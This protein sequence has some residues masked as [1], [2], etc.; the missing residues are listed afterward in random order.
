[1]KPFRISKG[2]PPR[3]R[4]SLKPLPTYESSSDQGYPAHYKNRYEGES[5]DQNDENSRIYSQKPRL[6]PKSHNFDMTSNLSLP[7]VRKARI[8]EFEH[9]IE[10]I[11]SSN[12]QNK[13]KKISNIILILN[14]CLLLS[15]DSYISFISEGDF[16]EGTTNLSYDSQL[17][18]Q[19]ADHRISNFQHLANSWRETLPEIVL[20][21]SSL[22][23]LLKLVKTYCSNNYLRF[24][25]S[26]NVVVAFNLI[27]EEDRGLRL[28]TS[29]DQIS[30]KSSDTK[31]QTL[32]NPMGD[33]HSRK[34]GMSG[35]SSQSQQY[36]NILKGVK[37]FNNGVLTLRKMKTDAILN[38]RYAKPDTDDFEMREVWHTYFYKAI[39]SLSD[40][41]VLRKS[42][43]TEAHKRYHSGDSRV[44]RK[45]KSTGYS[46]QDAAYLQSVDYIVGYAYY[47]LGVLSKSFDLR[48]AKD[49]LERSYQFFYNFEDTGMLENINKELYGLEYQRGYD[50]V[51]ILDYAH[52][53]FNKLF[54]IADSFVPLITKLPKIDLPQFTYYKG[55]ASQN[56]M[57]SVT[58]SVS[59]KLRLY[60][61]TESSPMTP[62][63]YILKSP[64]EEIRS[65]SNHRENPNFDQMSYKYYRNSKHKNSHKGRNRPM[66]SQHKTQEIL[67]RKDYSKE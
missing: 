7:I 15:I 44:S 26:S 18:Q 23:K 49:S 25:I 10:S 37:H 22:I 61:D 50:N 1:M 62:T 38:Q 9:D 53:V 6:P 56:L 19:L 65:H 16:E 58:R 5:S 67:I 31:L 33:M 47:W 45:T 2:R 42:N 13:K 8:E 52:P 27:N 20:N 36:V 54:W 48:Q 64:H 32:Y 41:V 59:Q 3:N 21:H 17:S 39:E 12:S 51:E 46:P 60:E 57:A 11:I 29:L 40:P 55:K 24:I 28:M 43:Y 30:F 66:T 35:V 14:K 4:G 34:S 63:N